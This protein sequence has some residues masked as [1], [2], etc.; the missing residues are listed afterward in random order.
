MARQYK[1]KPH[2][3]FIR[4]PASL[5][6]VADQNKIFWYP[7]GRRAFWSFTKNNNFNYS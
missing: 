6:N 7:N 2:K 4:N 3:N 5:T 1:M